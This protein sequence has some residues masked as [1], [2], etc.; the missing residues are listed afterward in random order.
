M[1]TSPKSRKLFGCDPLAIVMAVGIALCSVFFGMER[2][3]PVTSEAMPIYG[4]LPMPVPKPYT[5][6]IRPLSPIVQ[7][8]AMR[9][10]QRINQKSGTHR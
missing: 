5:I 6:Q 9:R 10:Q 7:T 3:L 4:A 2:L 1:S 8:A